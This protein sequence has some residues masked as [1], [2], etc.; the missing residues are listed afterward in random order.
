MSGENSSNSGFKRPNCPENS[1]AGW[2]NGRGY[3]NKSSDNYRGRGNHGRSPGG[4]NYNNGPASSPDN[5]YGFRDDERNSN[6]NFHNPNRKERRRSQSN[7]RQRS[8]SN[9]RGGSN[10]RNGGSSGQNNSQD[11]KRDRSGSRDR[12]NQDWMS[13]QSGDDSGYWPQNSPQHGH[14]RGGN[15]YGSPQKHNRGRQQ[16]GYGSSDSQTPGRYQQRWDED[17]DVFLSKT[18]SSILRHNAERFGFQL[19]KGG[20]LYV[21]EILRYVKKLNGFKIED[22]IRV[23]ESNDKKRFSLEN[24]EGRLKIR[25]NQGH[26]IEVEDLDLKPILSADEV[27]MVI[28]GTYYS[29][30][31]LI[32]NTGLNRMN[33]NHIHF[34]AGVPGENGVISGMRKTCEVMIHIDLEKALK[35]KYNHS[36]PECRCKDFCQDN[37]P[38]FTSNIV[39]ACTKTMICLSLKC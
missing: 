7:E 25:A 17:P 12:Q 21:D 35:G 30:W 33:R 23:V 6:S 18:L 24:E 29:S 11:H 32:K 14:D 26:S 34:A 20:F 31:E 37:S 38:I 4:W 8:G 39:F 3:P 27:P 16:G 13:P 9:S 28:H 19:M 1:P 15:R 10:D 22:V 36:I 2:N 5:H